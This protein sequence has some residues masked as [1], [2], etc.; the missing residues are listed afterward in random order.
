M[1]LKNWAFPK[2]LDKKI[3]KDQT[4]PAPKKTKGSNRLISME[5]SSNKISAF[6]LNIS[7][8]FLL[9]CLPQL[10]SLQQLWSAA[11]IC[12]TLH[13]IYDPV[14]LLIHAHFPSVKAEDTDVF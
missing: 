2:R 12:S 3:N 10:S 11:K 7:L 6:P 9:M 5:Q 4:K 8:P 14:M 1:V 13:V